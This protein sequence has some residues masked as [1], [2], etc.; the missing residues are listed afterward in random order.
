M[1]LAVD[2]KIALSD[3]RSIPQLGLGVWQTRAG[4]TCET[5]VLTA[6]QAGYRHIDSAALYGNEESVGAA[7]RASGLSREGIFVTTKLWNDDHGSPERALDASLRKLKLDYNCP[8]CAGFP[9]GSESN[10]RRKSL[11]AGRCNTSWW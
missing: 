6:L 1:K 3:G 7:I 2:T 11:F 4:R 5:A 10:Q 9:A 8:C